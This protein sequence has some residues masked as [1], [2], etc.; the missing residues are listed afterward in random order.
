[1]S[2]AQHVPRPQDGDV[3]STCEQ[4]LLALGAH[5]DITLHDRRGL[6]HAQVDEVLNAGI[7]CG[8][9]RPEAGCAINRPEFRRF[10]RAG[11]GHADQLYKRRAWRHAISVAGR[12]ERIPRYRVATCSQLLLAAYTYQRSDVVSACDQLLD[13][14]SPDVSCAAGNENR[15]LAHVGSTR[16][17]V[18]RILL[19]PGISDAPHDA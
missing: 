5:R 15:V 6:S 10:G 8:S 12:I 2:W 3:H 4:G 1:M 19:L 16:Q 18:Q 11:M 17:R 14:R 13:Q 9:Y 7:P